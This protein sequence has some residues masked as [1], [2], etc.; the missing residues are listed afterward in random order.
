MTASNLKD[1]CATRKIFLDLMGYYHMSLWPTGGVGLE[2]L[3]FNSLL[4]ALFSRCYYDGLA[5]I[6]QP[7]FHF[8]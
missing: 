1:Y 2:P 4:L 6:L 3:N 5:G 8:A 7:Q